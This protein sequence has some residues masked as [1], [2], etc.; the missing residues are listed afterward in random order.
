M[1]LPLRTAVP[2][3]VAV[4]HD[5]RSRAG[6]IFALER[7]GYEVLA[8]RTPGP[9]LEVLRSRVPAM[10]IADIE[11]EEMSG[12]DLCLVVKREE[13]LE[14]VPV[15][16][17]TR[18]G[19]PSDYAMAHALGATI[20]MTKPYKRDRLMLV[21]HMLAVPTGENATSGSAALR[22]RTMA[23]PPATDSKYRRQ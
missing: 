3:V 21:A 23:L 5:D 6:L 20:C 2:M 14:R 11:S 4:D 8:F 1:Y 12:Y 22:G 19:L 10:V 13:R 7:E 16:L 17:T 15:V 18:S 9:A